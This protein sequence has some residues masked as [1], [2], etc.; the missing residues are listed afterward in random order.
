MEFSVGTRLVLR[1]ALEAAMIARKFTLALLATTGMAVT[2]AAYAADVYVP[3]PADAAMAP[4]PAAWSWTGIYFGINGGY[5]WG[6][7]TDLTFGHDTSPAGWLFGGQVGA[8]Y[9]FGGGLVLGI[10]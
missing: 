5:G 6:T 7:A 9:Q 4:A 3:P 8:N 2:G 1:D 10:E